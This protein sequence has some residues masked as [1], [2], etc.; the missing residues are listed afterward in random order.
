MPIQQRCEICGRACYAQRCHVCKRNT[1][2]DK[3]IAFLVS[4]EPDA[5]YVLYEV[6]LWRL[7][8]NDCIE[9]ESVEHARLNE[10]FQRW[11]QTY[12]PIYS[13]SP[14]GLTQ[15]GNQRTS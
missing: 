10:V 14:Y 15:L 5:S 6:K 4:V 11:N 13:F 9:C 3:T 7:A 12:G 2:N 1:T 8:S